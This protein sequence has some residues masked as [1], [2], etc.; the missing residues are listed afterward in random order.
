MMIPPSDKIAI[1]FPCKICTHRA[2]RHYMNI[3]EGNDLCL[4]CAL[5]GRGTNDEEH[6]HTFVGDNLK[7]MELQVKKQE[8]RNE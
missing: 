8:L 5:G 4:D 6:W 7:Y 1:D 2:N 3:S